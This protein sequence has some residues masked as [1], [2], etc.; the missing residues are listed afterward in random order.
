[1]QHLQ[2]RKE[3]RGFKKL[4]RKMKYNRKYDRAIKAQSYWN[5]EK[6]KTKNEVVNNKEN[7]IKKEKKEDKEETVTKLTNSEWLNHMRNNHQY[8]R[9]SSRRAPTIESQM[10][11][12]VTD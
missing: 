12:V 3:M 7:E 10:Y 4:Q 9:L 8:D 1:M 6:K 2:I 11:R 5:E